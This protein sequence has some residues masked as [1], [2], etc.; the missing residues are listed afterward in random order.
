MAGRFKVDEKIRLGKELIVAIRE[1]KLE[2]ARELINRGADINTRGELKITPLMNAAAY[3]H[4][5]IGQFLINRGAKI[6]A[7]DEFDSEF[8]APFGTAYRLAILKGHTD[9]LKMLETAMDNAMKGSAN[10]HVG[11][12][13]KAACHNQRTKRQILEI[14]RTSN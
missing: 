8:S 12:L 11:K 3:G 9:F 6:A 5:G 7:R 10:Y 14:L 2:K 1:G 13:W 4:T